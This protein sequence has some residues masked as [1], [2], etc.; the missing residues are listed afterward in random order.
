M[1]VDAERPRSTHGRAA[2]EVVVAQR[3]QERAVAGEL[4]EL[5]GGDPSPTARLLPAARRRAT[6]SPAAGMCGTRANVD[7]LD[8]PDDRGADRAHE[9]EVPSTVH[10]MP[11]DDQGL[12]L[13]AAAKALGVS[14]DT[15][16]R[17][18]RAGKLETVRDER[19]RRRVPAAEVERLSPH[20]RRHTASARSRR[21]TA[22]P[23]SSA[24]SRWTA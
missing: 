23:A 5:D 10:S 24:R 18:D 21:A 12:T 3:G 16:R 11:A 20:P 9:V 1:H 17:W 6:I 14:I 22:F 19:G 13:G 7:P 2:A 8:V 4:D 15:L